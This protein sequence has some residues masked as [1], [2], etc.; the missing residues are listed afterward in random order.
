MWCVCWGVCVWGGEFVG[1]VCVGVVVVLG[2]CVCWGGVCVGV[3]CV[4]VVCVLGWCV[5]VG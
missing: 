5:C 4:G 3:V 2:W 1:D